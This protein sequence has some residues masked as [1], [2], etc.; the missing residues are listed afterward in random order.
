MPAEDFPDFETALLR[1]GLPKGHQATEGR[2]IRA[3]A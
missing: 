1:S 3:L 2:I